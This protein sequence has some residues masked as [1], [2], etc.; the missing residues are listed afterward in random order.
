MK[1]GME[2]ADVSQDGSEREQKMYRRRVW[3]GNNRVQIASVNWGIRGQL[4]LRTSKQDRE[5]TP[6][7]PTSRLV[8]SETQ[9]SEKRCTANIIHLHRW[10][11]MFVL[12][13]IVSLIWYILQLGKRRIRSGQRVLQR[14]SDGI[15]ALK[16]ER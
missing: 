4:Q 9:I 1:K 14:I 7:N 15:I 16:E 6:Q 11:E 12:K 13:G 3:Q 5:R 10:A 8:G 2:G